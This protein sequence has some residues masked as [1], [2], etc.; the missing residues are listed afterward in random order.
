[1]RLMRAQTALASELTYGTPI[2]RERRFE[3]ARYFFTTNGAKKAA[4][5]GG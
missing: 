1:M 5:V 2:L 3:N 4:C